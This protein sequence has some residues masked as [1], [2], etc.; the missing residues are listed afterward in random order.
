MY[1]LMSLWLAI[2]VNYCLPANAGQVET[3]LAN[4]AGSGD[5][6]TFRGS[7]LSDG[8]KGSIR[9]HFYMAQSVAGGMKFQVNGTCYYT[10]PGS[11][12][13]L[14]NAFDTEVNTEYLFADSASGAVSDVCD[15]NSKEHRGQ[16]SESKLGVQIGMCGKAYATL[17]FEKVGGALNVSYSGHD[18]DGKQVICTGP[19]QLEP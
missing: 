10:P 15:D 12:D 3:F 9:V 14:Q 13:E 5:G 6:K 7:N 2:S 17:S 4:F 16:M 8:N 11:K 18:F 19:V 1:R